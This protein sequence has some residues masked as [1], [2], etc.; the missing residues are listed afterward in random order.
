MELKKN[1]NSCRLEKDGFFSINHQEDLNFKSLSGLF[2]IYMHVS[3]KKVKNID[4]LLKKVVL[5]NPKGK[6]SLFQ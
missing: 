5:G 3:T 2:H 1:N 6:R 4:I